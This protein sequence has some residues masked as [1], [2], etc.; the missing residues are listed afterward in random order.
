MIN[1]TLKQEQNRVYRLL[2]NALKNQHLAH[3]ILFSGN[4]NALKMDAALL[5][6]A[7]IVQDKDQ[8][9]DENDAIYQRIKAGNYYDVIVMDGDSDTVKTEQVE[10]LMSRFNLSGLE[11]SGKKVYVINNVNNSSTK[12]LNSLLKFLEEPRPGIYAILISDD[13]NGL[14]KTIV[15]RCEIIEFKSRSSVE[16]YSAY[17]A[18][19]FKE[20]DAYLLS[21][22]ATDLPVY[23]EDVYRLSKQLR[24]KFLEYNDQPDEFIVY[25]INTYS[26]LLKDRKISDKQYPI[27][28]L[29]LRMMLM[30]IVDVRIKDEFEGAYHQDLVRMDNSVYDLN[31]LQK[32][33]LKIKKLAHQPYNVRLLI[34]KFAYLVSRAAR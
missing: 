9:V 11:L 22:L 29:F 31:R 30:L 8:L 28:Q 27:L 18:D 4:R 14:L 17:A 32:A 20:D 23:E 34:D 15:S 25:A 7:S 2:N 5:L 10:D 16:I 3:S 12:V 6:A 1:Q 24:D 13:I 26:D 33:I 21:R 19:G